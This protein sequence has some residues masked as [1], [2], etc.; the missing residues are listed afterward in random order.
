MENADTRTFTEHAIKY[1][2][3]KKSY[4]CVR[5]RQSGDEL[6]LL[7]KVREAFCMKQ[8][9]EELCIPAGAYTVAYYWLDRPYNAY[10]WLNPEGVYLG[11][12]FNLVE[13]TVVTDDAVTFH[14]MIVD[15]LAMPDGSYVVLDEEELPSP[16][17][18]FEGGSVERHLKA[19]T[20][21]ISDTMRYLDRETYR[22]IASGSIR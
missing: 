8:G 18:E 5:L 9:D 17:P 12:Y 19:L 16:M 7:H 14:D 3:T 21:S 6:V 4:P 20:D 11:T 2:G 22:L 1:D 13:R 15:V 10:Y